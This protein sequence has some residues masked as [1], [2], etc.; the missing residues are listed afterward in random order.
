MIIIF[1]FFLLQVSRVENTCFQWGMFLTCVSD[2]QRIKNLL[3]NFL[4]CWLS[5][6]AISYSTINNFGQLHFKT[7]TFIY[8]VTSNISS[9]QNTVSK[10]YKMSEKCYMIFHMGSHYWCS[11][12]NLLWESTFV[13]SHKF[14]TSLMWYSIAPL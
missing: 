9:K 12:F 6:N 5:N 2:V 14:N 3:E 8:D 13:S 11:V 4:I 1:W 10:F 7:F